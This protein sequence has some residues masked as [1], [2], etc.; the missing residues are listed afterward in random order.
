MTRTDTA[1]PRPS[2]GG[3]RFLAILDYDGTI[4]TRECMEIVFQQLIGD[5]W[6]PFEDDVRAGR[7]SPPEGL[8]RQ[9]ALVRAPRTQFVGA[10]VAAAQPLPG[11]A[12]FLD[13]LARRGGRGAV[14]SAGLRE[15]IATV[16]QRE[17]LPSLPLY[18]SELAPAGPGGT[19]PPF[20]LV[21]NAAFGDCPRC[22]P[23]GCK[24]AVL[25]ALRR[26]GDTVLVFGDGAS[27]LCLAR[28]A[29]LTFA[30]G[31]LAACCAAEHLTWRRLIDY[32]TVWDEIDA[33]PATPPASDPPRRLP[34]G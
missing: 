14:V 11:F 3:G 19:E 31:H 34:P 23:G 1:P 4:T 29:D 15:A 25:R 6:R 20:A 2:G 5:A 28:E 27:D 9:V 7:L 17:Q 13:E 21:H 22:G 8:R 30:H 32:T 18:A 24:A 10:L 33:W 12:A 26:P 16:W